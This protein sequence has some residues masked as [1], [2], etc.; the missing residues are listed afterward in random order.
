MKSPLLSKTLWLN[1]L[2]A[3][4]ALVGLPVVGDY[5]T[6]HPDIVVAVWSVANMVLRLVSKDKL[7]LDA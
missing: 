2:V 1:A 4:G 3:V 5:L 6:S 7:A